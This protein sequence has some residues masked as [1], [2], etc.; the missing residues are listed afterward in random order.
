MSRGG[1]G[2]DTGPVAVVSATGRPLRLAARGRENQQTSRESQQE[3]GV[4]G[5]GNSV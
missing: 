2:L 1:G 3:T 4:K 5:A